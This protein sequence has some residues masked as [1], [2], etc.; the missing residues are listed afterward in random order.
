MKM[1]SPIMFTTT[2]WDLVPVTELNGDTGS[3]FYKTQQFDGLRVRIVEYSANYRADHWCK[4]GHI[5]YCLEG[6]MV[7]E[8]ADGRIFTISKGMSYIVSDDAS[9]HR[10]YSEHG[11][12]LMIIDGKF[13]NNKHIERNP[14]KM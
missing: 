6:Q 3:A 11:V 2:N 12:K 9:C 7:S 14:W 1:M 4:A 5:V 13:L 8:L 10:S